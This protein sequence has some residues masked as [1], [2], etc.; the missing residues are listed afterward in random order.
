MVVYAGAAGLVLPSTSCSDRDTILA[1]LHHLEAGGSTNGAAGIELAYQTAAGSFIEGGV[2]RVILATD[3]D[4]NVGATSREELD[5]LIA[6]KAQGGIFLTVLG[7]GTGN[8]KDDRLEALSNRGN[9]NYAYLDTLEEARKVLMQQVAGTLVTIARD[10][11]VQVEFNPQVVTSYRLI[12][13]ENRMLAP[14]DFNDDRKDAGEIGAG[15]TVTAL[16]EV[17]PVGGGSPPEVDPLKYQ[18]APPPRPEGVSGEMLTVKLRYKAPEGG[19]SQRV[20]LPLTDAGLGYS[21]ASVDFKLAASVAAFGMI[22]RGSPSVGS[23]RL[24]G[25]LELA[26]EGK[27]K[28]E[29]GRR[30]E[31]VELIRQARR[32]MPGR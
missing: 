31:L 2:N 3:G 17:V 14:E 22:L 10:V 18:P 26:G 8:L 28:D 27:G 15:H 32:L 1:A 11:K 6:E 4:F 5:R 16:Y 21:D 20:E 29:Q 7:V 12:G 23:L 9:G 30:A 19:S 25:V 13:H 24:D